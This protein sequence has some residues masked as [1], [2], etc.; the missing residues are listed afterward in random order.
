MAT[1]RQQFGTLLKV[2][3]SAGIVGF[4]LTRVDLA[5]LWR[6]ARSVGS[7]TFAF[8]FALSILQNVLC[9]IRWDVV[10]GALSRRLRFW[11]ALQANYVSVCLGQCLPSVVG[12]DAYRIYWL[13][14][15]GHALAVSIRALLLDRISAVL[16]LVLMLGTGVPWILLR[17]HDVAVLTAVAVTLAGGVC[18]ALALLCGD[19]L[20]IAWRRL[21]VVAELAVLS[22]SARRVLLVPYTGVQVM[23]LS[24]LVHTLTAVAMFVFARDMG[25]PLYFLDCVVLVPLLTVVSALPISIAGWGVREGAMVAALS[26][27]GVRPDQSLVLSI[28]LGIQPLLN[29]LIGAA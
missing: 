13:Y 2:A 29:G 21:R 18:A 11:P 28:L 23:S 19:R 24:L 15:Q 20:P 6:N 22:A 17:F 4:I 3:I 26:G 10:M 27:L 1:T 14:R 5:A 25:L 7:V 12:G 8:V 9:V 16:A